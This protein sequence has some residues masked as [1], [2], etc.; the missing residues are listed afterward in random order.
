MQFAR[1]QRYFRDLTFKCSLIPIAVLAPGLCAPQ[2]NPNA[3]LAH[4]IPREAVNRANAFLVA[5]NGQSYLF[6]YAADIVKEPFLRNVYKPFGL[7]HDS[8]RVLYLKSQGRLPGFSLYS[9]DLDTNTETLLADDSV[10]FAAWSP[11]S[12]DVA[13]VTF[14]GNSNLRVVLLDFT[15][16]V[17]TE[18]A[19]GQ[20]EPESLD[21]SPGGDELLY[22]SLLPRSRTYLHDQRFEFALNRYQVRRKRRNRSRAPTGGDSRGRS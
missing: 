10:Q 8:R 4:A 14:D 18:V 15:S 3:P 12:L 1:L 11:V 13:Y 5:Y 22:V 6:N 20:I 16:N 21:W 17:K 2:D 7:S 9:Y 19:R